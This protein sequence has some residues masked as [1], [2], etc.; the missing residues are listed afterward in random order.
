VADALVVL[1]NKYHTQEN[2]K[3]R[4]DISRENLATIAGTAT[5][6]LIRTLSDFKSEKI[7]DI[8][9]GYISIINDKKLEGMIN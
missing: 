2:D 9:D 5:E 1:K 7:I 3:F 8:K 4:I 6:S